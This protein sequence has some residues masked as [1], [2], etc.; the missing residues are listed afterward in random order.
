MVL[1]NGVASLIRRVLPQPEQRAARQTLWLGAITVAQFLASIVQVAVSAR[2]LGPEGLGVVAV[3]IA[4]TSLLYRLVSLPGNEVI[5]TFVT[6]SIAEGRMEEAT[7]TLRFTMLVSQGLSLVSYVLLAAVTLA[8]SG[9]LGEAEGYR[10]ALLVYGVGG[11]AAATF[12]ESMA[13]LRLADR[14]QLGFAVAVVSSAAR[15]A[16]LVAA[17]MAGGGLIMV[18]SAY[19]VGDVVTGVGMFLAAACSE[20]QAGLPGFLRSLRARVPGRDVIAFQVGSFWRASVE[21]VILHIDVILVANVLSLHQVG[22]Y[23]AAYQIVDATKHPFRS[24]ATGV[25][26]EYSRQWYGG[27]AAAVRGLAR[28]FTLLALAIAVAGYGLL[29]IMH[30]PVIR[31]MLG[32]GFEEAAFPLLFMIPGAL[33]FAVV[34]P[35]SVLPAAIGRAV[36][37]LAAYS[38][39][40][41]AMVVAIL[42]LAPRYGAEGAAWANSI[43]WIAFAAAFVPFIVRTLR[44]GDD[45]V[46]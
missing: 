33:A 18:I 21:A 14:L 30:G 8:V 32:A 24:I 46:R 2:I 23:R 4:L 31:I 41:V 39:A 17:W 10:S 28:R 26:A 6:R 7:G 20:R 3:I 40:L 35:V 11:V 15:T 5:T 9:L 22:L 42:A 1:K 34:A 44:Q 16:F 27:D 45:A 36:P 43:G 25:Q 37:H 38:V 19:V 13:V 12:R 29:V